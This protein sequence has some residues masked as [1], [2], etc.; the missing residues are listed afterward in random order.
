MN[1]DFNNNSNEMSMFNQRRS[2]SIDFEFLIPKAKNEYGPLSEIEPSGQREKFVLVLVTGG[3][4]CMKKNIK[5]NYAPVPG[6]LSEAIPTISLL[7]DSEYY[8][9]YIESRKE[10]NT[11]CM[12]FRQ[13]LKD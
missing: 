12:S 4:L 1:N 10:L 7:H 8:E 3:T 6:F 13:N 5:G 9:Q 11:R 2:S